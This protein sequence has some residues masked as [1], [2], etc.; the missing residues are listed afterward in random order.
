LIFLACLFP[1]AVYCFILSILNR[2]SHPA[3]VS[4]AWD[5]AG[6]LFAA[7]GFV[8]FGGPAILSNFSEQWRVLWLT[9][10]RASTFGLGEESGLF[11]I[12]LF[13]LYFVA[14]V[15]TSVYLLRGRRNSTS[16]YNIQ[17]ETLER[18]LGSVLDNMGLCWARAGDRL[19]ITP[20]NGLRNDPMGAKPSAVQAPH[21]AR[22]AVGERLSQGETE[23]GRP[24]PAPMLAAD[25]FFEN[26]AVVA[27]D[28]FP[29]MRHATLRWESGDGLLREE[30]E[31]E[32][33]RALR[34][35]FTGSNPAG[36]WLLGAASSLL[37]L[38]FL[39]LAFLIFLL[40]R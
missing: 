21:L 8:V 25:G 36:A 13:V 15:A 28:Y 16:I 39:G 23:Q 32:L 38:V 7:S 10:R 4:G 34:D 17:A 6:I 9:G 35:V 30:L 24:Y 18:V 2:R 19:F 12:L 20:A 27:L 11:Y 31:A 1:L 37:M 22:A 5:F 26:G 3:V 14:V 33:T 40:T 29:T